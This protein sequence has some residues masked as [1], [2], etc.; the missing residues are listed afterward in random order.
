MNLLTNISI[1]E[2]RTLLYSE[3]IEDIR[4]SHF[5]SL[6]KISMVPLL[7]EEILVDIHEKKLVVWLVHQ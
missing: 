5:G 7:E 2:A 6:D 3:I 1:I 4:L